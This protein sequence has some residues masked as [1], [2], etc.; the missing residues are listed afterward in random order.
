MGGV[1]KQG[2]VQQINSLGREA[3]SEEQTSLPVLRK[4]PCGKQEVTYPQHTDV[5]ITVYPAVFQIL[6]F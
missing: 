4:W 3:T 1:G 6:S 5:N 2:E